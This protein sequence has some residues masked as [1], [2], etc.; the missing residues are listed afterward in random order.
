[1]MVEGLDGNI[2]TG[3][4]GWGLD[5]RLTTLLYKKNIV[6]KSKEVKTRWCNSQEGTNLAESEE[7]YS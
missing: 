2:G 7:G 4:A 1:M 3:Q 5:A 6:A